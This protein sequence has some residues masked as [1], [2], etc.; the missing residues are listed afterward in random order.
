MR[1]FQLVICGTLALGAYANFGSARIL[2]VPGSYPTIGAAI[3][4]SIEEDTILV[5]QGRYFEI[6]RFPHYRIYVLSHFLFS[7]DSTDLAQTIIDASPFADQDTAC[8]VIFPLS[9]TGSVLSGFT[10]TGGHG[11]RSAFPGFWYAGAIYVDTCSPTISHNHIIGN[12]SAQAGVGYFMSCSGSFEYNRV[13]SNTFGYVQMQIIYNVLQPAMHIEY[14]EFGANPAADTSEGP[15]ILV[16]R[17]AWAVI[18]GNTFANQV[19]KERLCISYEGRDAVITRNRFLNLHAVGLNPYII[20]IES[21]VCEFSD[22]DFLHIVVEGHSVVQMYSGG[23]G[24]LTMEN[25]MFEDIVVGGGNWHIGM[26]VGLS[27]YT[28]VIR[29]NVFRN[30]RGD[31]TGG[32]NV[33]GSPNGI[34]LTRNVFEACSTTWWLDFMSGALFLGG[35]R[36]VIARDNIFRNNYPGAVGL[37]SPQSWPASDFRYNYWGDA[38]GPYHPILNP[39]GMGDRVGDSVLFIP[40]LTDTNFTAAPE[41]HVPLPNTVKLEVYPNPFN[42]ATAIKLSVTHPTAIRLELFNLLGQREVELWSGLVASEQEITLDGSKTGLSSGI[43][44]VRATDVNEN[45]SI[46][47]AKLILLK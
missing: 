31:Y 23:G 18:H 42:P 26:T 21:S 43:Y 30:L 46:A 15:C 44:F 3:T 29:Y 8:A 22:N 47:S 13:D 34:E 25:N 35:D 5:E 19:G 37:S 36:P 32:I 7:Y 24:L 28:G 2:Q 27:G 38:S 33:G 39:N 1:T 4:S 45:K 17:D 12:V 41:S 20:F 16:D 10:I 9:A 14:N 6:L 11:I 40:W